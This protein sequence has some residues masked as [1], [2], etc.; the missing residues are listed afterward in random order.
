M[1]DALATRVIAAYGGE[2]RWRA[3]NA[4]EA[5]VSMGGMLLRL[6]GHLERSLRDMRTRTEIERP[7]VRIEPIDREGNV[8]I[9]DRHDVRIERP[10]GTL[11]GE[12]RDTRRLFP[13]RGT[14]WL[15]WDRL[16][17]LYFI[18]YTQ[19][20]YNAFP[21]LLWRD[22]IEWRE[23]DDNVLEAR[24]APH[25]PTH[26]SVQRFHIDPATGLLAQMDYTAEVF[27]AWAKGAHVIEA[28]GETEGVPYPSRR[29]VWSRKRDDSPRLSPAP[30]M[31]WLDAHEWR[32]LADKAAA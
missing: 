9:L 23:L 10:D 25:L 32:L 22:D 19:W 13:Y 15:R 21:A 16:D 7:R 20:T 5:R 1:A 6:K 29:R 31:I 30:L 27:G 3:A 12:R 2:E 17:A 4:V 11:V 8:G 26:S 18:G 24:F 14:R 28:H